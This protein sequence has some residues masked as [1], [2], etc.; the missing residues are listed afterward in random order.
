VFAEDK[1]G[2]FYGTLEVVGLKDAQFA[3]AV[4][5]S[6]QIDFFCQDVREDQVGRSHLK[7][8]GENGI[9]D[10]FNRHRH[11]IIVLSHQEK[12]SVGPGRPFREVGCY[13]RRAFDEEDRA[14]GERIDKMSRQQEKAEEEKQKER[15]FHDLEFYKISAA[16]SSPKNHIPAGNIDNGKYLL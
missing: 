10:L 2:F 16:A 13:F 5:E 12:H 6:F 1:N 15:L 11:S 7:V 3:M 8:H 9:E 14:Q 4:E